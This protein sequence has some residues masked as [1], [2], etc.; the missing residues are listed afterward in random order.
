VNQEGS[1]LKLNDQ[2]CF[3]IYASSRL[4]TRLYQPLLDKLG[5][6]YPQYLVMMVLWENDYQKVTA[7]GKQLFLNTNTLTPLITKLIT[8]GLISK[9]RSEND[10]RAVFVSLTHT[11]QELKDQ[12]ERIPYELASTMDIPVND[13]LQLKTIMWEVLKKLDDGEQ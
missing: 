9:K 10:E 8:K 11:G 12:A 3:P 6:T 5:L 4:I 7:I 1:R 2:V 13:L